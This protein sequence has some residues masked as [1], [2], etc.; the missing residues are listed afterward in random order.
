M[1]A[2]QIDLTQASHKKIYE[3]VLSAKEPS[4]Q[5]GLTLEHLIKHS[6]SCS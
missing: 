2:P 4:E 3:T 1:L 6:L 5:L